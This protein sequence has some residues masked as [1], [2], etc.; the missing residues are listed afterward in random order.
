MPSA[1]PMPPLRFALALCA[2]V[3][4]AA[5][6]TLH[7]QTAD[8][9]PERPITL[10]CPWTPGGNTDIAL[11]ALADV[12][13]RH[14]GKRIV[15][16]N[17]PGAGGALGPQNMAAGAKPDGYT[18]SQIPL[19]VFRLPPMVRTTFDPL[20]YLTWILHIAGCEFGVSVRA[21]SPWKTRGGFI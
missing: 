9:F 8:N 11:R 10:I 6:S 21:H 18:L 1:M 20:T 4:L 16:E 2:C 19:G 15:I 12:A 7:A 3:M 5:A 14:L 17:K 13:A